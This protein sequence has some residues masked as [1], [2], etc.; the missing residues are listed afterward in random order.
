MDHA[1]GYHPVKRRGDLQIR[2]Q[3]CSDR[4]AAC[5]RPESTAAATPTAP[6][7]SPPAFRP[8]SPRCPRSRQEF[9][10][11]SS[12]ARTCSAPP[13]VVPPPA[14]RSASAA[15]TLDSASA[16]C[17]AISGALNS[18]SRSPCLTTLPRSTSTLSTYPRTLACTETVWNGRNSP[19]S[20][21]VRETGFATTGTSSTVCAQPARPAAATGTS[22]E[23][24]EVTALHSIGSRDPWD[25]VRETSVDALPCRMA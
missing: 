14:A 23:E 7:R 11:P 5:A 20:S 2:L 8:G 25:S 9:R 19:G 24:N 6:A 18:T 22:H 12:A 15:C 16:I 4:T 10:Q 3:S 21:M 17:A 1:L 13:R